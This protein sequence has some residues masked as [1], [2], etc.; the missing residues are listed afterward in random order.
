V[1]TLRGLGLTVEI[2]TWTAGYEVTVDWVLGHL[3]SALPAGALRAGEAGGPADAVQTALQEL[4]E[5]ALM[6]D[7]TTSALIARRAG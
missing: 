1:Q 3:G 4:S 6:E 5:Q 2:A 7:V